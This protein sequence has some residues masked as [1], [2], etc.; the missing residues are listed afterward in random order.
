MNKKVIYIENTL[1][2]NEY[3]AVVKKIHPEHIEFIDSYKDVLNQKGGNWRFQKNYQSIILAKRRD[4]FF[5]KASPLTQV[6]ESKN[7][8]YNTLA[9]NCL[10]DCEYC[11]LQGMFTTP[12]LVLFLNNQDFISETRKLSSSLGEPFYMAI[13]YDTDLPALEHWYPYCSEWIDYAASDPNITI[14]IRSKSGL[15]SHFSTKKPLKNVILS[16]SIS[17]NEI[18]SAYEHSTP[19]LEHRIKAINHAIS[20]GWRVMLC[21][22]PI[23]KIKGYQEIYSRFIKYITQIIDLKKIYGFSIGTF[24]M[25][26]NYLNNIRAQ[27]PESSLLWYPYERNHQH[28]G[29][30]ENE[31]KKLIQLVKFEL[32]QIGVTKIFE[33]E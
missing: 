5:Y 18:L 4:T 27:R 3:A 28:A 8:Y 31:K 21:I 32:E 22:D 20:Q 25:H 11:Y 15:K 1:V 24:R 30:P 7:F 12:H 10:F 33:Y 6:I 23:I 2:E 19:S 16:W 26:T 17:P 14:E 29:Y 13:S 9:I